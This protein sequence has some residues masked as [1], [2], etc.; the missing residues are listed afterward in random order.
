MLNINTGAT[1]PCVFIGL[2]AVT[3]EGGNYNIHPQNGFVLLQ[4]GGI[5]FSYLGIM[6][7]EGGSEIKSHKF[8][9]AWT[10]NT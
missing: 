6:G 8:D 10:A 7:W 1:P 5:V 4:T 2:G 9:H 3:E